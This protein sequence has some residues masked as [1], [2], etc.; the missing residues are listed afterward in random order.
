MSYVDTEQVSK[1][2][3]RWKGYLDEDS[4]MRMKYRII[5]IPT[6]DVTE[7]KHGKWVMVET[8]YD[9]GNSAIYECSLCGRKIGCDRYPTKRV[10]GSDYP[11]AV[12]VEE[13]FPYCHCGAKMEVE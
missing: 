4:I 6:A 10:P 13:L 11:I 5:D 12:S 2:L 9:I 1:W 8:E 7:V 3:D